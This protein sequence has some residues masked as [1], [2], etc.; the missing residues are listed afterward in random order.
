[1][2][3]AQGASSWEGLAL[4]SISWEAGWE[5]RGSNYMEPETLPNGGWVW[6]SRVLARG[7]QEVQLSPGEARV[8]SVHGAGPWKSPLRSSG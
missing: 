7:W 6:S 5:E 3:A 2:L 8:P 1:M 4:R